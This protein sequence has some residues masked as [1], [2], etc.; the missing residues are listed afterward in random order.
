MKL[1]TVSSLVAVMALFSLGGCGGGD[2]GNSG[3]SVL[4]GNIQPAQV[5][6]V[7]LS[8]EG[9]ALTTTSSA[10]GV[11]IFTEVPAGNYSAVFTAGGS[12]HTMQIN[13]PGASSVELQNVRLSGDGTASAQNIA[14]NAVGAGST[15]I[16]GTWDGVFYSATSDPWRGTLVFDAG[17][18]LAS[19]GATGPETHGTYSVTG[20]TV[21]GSR[22]SG[23]SFTGQLSG[24][25]NVIAGTWR[26]GSFVLRRRVSS[27]PGNGNNGGNSGGNSSGGSTNTDSGGSICQTYNDYALCITSQTWTP[28][29]NDV[30]Q[31][32]YSVVL[33][34]TASG[35]VGATLMMFTA[36]IQYTLQADSWSGHAGPLEPQEAPGDPETTTWTVTVAYMAPGFPIT[37]ALA[38]RVVSSTMVEVEA[39]AH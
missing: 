5:A 29:H 33:N 11:F 15:D 24:E 30:G 12:A 23:D 19:Q 39:P 31:L 21:T 26:D 10:D 25:R 32:Y 28:H 2:D 34:G 7:S 3:P 27:P 20:S 37:I 14:V 17:G 36:N 13:V 18:V 16:Q 9:P 22:Y 4:Y 6:A 1:K 8:G 38:D 35:P